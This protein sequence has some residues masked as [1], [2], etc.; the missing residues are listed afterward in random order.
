MRT[1][2]AL[3]LLV[4]LG[5][6][7]RP[8]QAQ[9]GQNADDISVGQQLIQQD[10]GSIVEPSSATNKASLLQNGTLNQSSIDQRMLGVG[11]GNTALITQNGASNVAYILQAGAQNRTSVSQVGANNVALSEITGSN[12]ESDIVQRG[13]GNRV[14]QRLSVDDRRYTVEQMGTNN[15]LLQRESGTTAPGYEV[16][17]KGNGIRIV[18]EQGR[19][20]TMP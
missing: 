7:S 14:E 17:M 15:T 20:A 13:N 3:G 12:T 6:S 5:L 18:I 2:L 1:V 16:T 11:Q 4:I 19:V 9:S 8:G 10:A